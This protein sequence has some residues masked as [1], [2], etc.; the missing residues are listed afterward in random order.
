[1][2]ISAP[3]KLI[4]NHKATDGLAHPGPAGAVSPAKHARRNATRSVR[5]VAI[6]DGSI[7][8]VAGD[9][10]LPLPRAFRRMH[11]PILLPWTQMYKSSTRR[12]AV[13]HPIRQRHH[14]R[15][16]ASQKGRSDHHP[17]SSPS[18]LL[19]RRSIPTCTAMRT[20]PCLTTIFIS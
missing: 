6:A 17:T 12:V 1:M 11:H 20:A 4:P 8:L 3:V 2:A 7:C 19:V 5:A 9:V 14:L 10:L 15:R 18:H 16:R 13:V